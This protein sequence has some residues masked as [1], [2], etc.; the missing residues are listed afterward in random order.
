[1]SLF[2]KNKET[3]ELNK[4]MTALILSKSPLLLEIAQ[5]D[6]GRKLIIRTKYWLSK[7]DPVVYNFCK[8]SANNPSTIKLE[9]DEFPSYPDFTSEYIMRHTV[10]N[11]TYGFKVYSI[12]NKDKDIYVEFLTDNGWKDFS[13][14]K[15]DFLILCETFFS[16]SNISKI[17]RKLQEQ[18]AIHD[19]KQEYLKN[20]GG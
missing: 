2:T 5:N 15:C 6:E 16:L 19:S 1:M 7:A 3:N 14:N 17:D 11:I 20:Y 8:F 10:D 12:K 4:Y 9:K 18:R 13:Q